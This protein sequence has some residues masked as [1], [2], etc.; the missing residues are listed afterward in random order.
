MTSIIAGLVAALFVWALQILANRGRP[1]RAKGY[2][3]L[4]WPIGI[5]ILAL[6]MLPF[7]GFIVFAASQARPDQAT[8]AA[9]VAACF[10]LGSVY[11]AA[12][13]FLTRVWWTFE[14]IGMEVPF[15]RRR[16]VR[17]DDVEEGGYSAGLQAYYIR[18]HGTRIW[19]S[20]MQ[21]GIDQLHRFIGRKLKPVA[22]PD[23]PG[24]TASR[25]R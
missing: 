20:P 12:C 6:L 16:F 25:A 15:V 23:G 14:G 13:V 2:R 19:Y 18:G 10:V 5:R 24:A 11:L 7:A 17:W 4:R 1:A 3:E 8:I 21:S 9:V 22:P